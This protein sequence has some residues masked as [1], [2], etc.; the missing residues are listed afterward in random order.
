MLMQEV[1]LSQSLRNMQRITLSLNVE[2]RIYIQQAQ[3][4]MRLDLVEALRGDK[5]EPQA[6]CPKCSC[7]M[8]AL[9]IIKGFLPDPDD[10]T[11]ACSGCG[12]RFQPKLICHGRYSNIELPFFCAAQTLPK[13]F[14]KEG[15]SPE[16][17]LKEHPAIYHSAVV[18]FGGLTQAFERIGKKY[19]FTEINKNN[20]RDK[21]GPFLGH[22]SDKIIAECAGVSVNLVGKLRRSR[23]ISRYT[24]RQE[25][26]NLEI[27]TE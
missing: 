4:Q 14:G 10:F 22:L 7:K 11:T 23:G 6:T 1:S 3:L 9:E 2:Q 21:V 19:S 15:L 12:N 20:W 5:Y 24:I 17:M 8:T 18:H 16:E 25:L 26:E 27:E 13:L